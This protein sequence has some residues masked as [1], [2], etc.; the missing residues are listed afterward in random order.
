MAEEF[1]MGLEED[2][3]A[4]LDPEGDDFA[5]DEADLVAGD[6]LGVEGEEDIGSGSTITLSSDDV[7]EIRNLSVGDTFMLRVANI[8]DDGTFDFTPES[9]DQ[10]PV[11]EEGADVGRDAVLSSLGA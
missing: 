5:A 8:A 11:G 10:E 7:P 6:E 1:E 2:L 4:D 3:D 9:E